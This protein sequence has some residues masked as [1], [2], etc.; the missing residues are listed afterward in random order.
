MHISVQSHTFRTNSRLSVASVVSWFVSGL[1]L[2]LPQPP[3]NEEA[4]VTISLF[5]LFFHSLL[6]SRIVPL[7]FWKRILAIEALLSFLSQG[8][9][10]A[11]QKGRL[12]F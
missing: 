3:A 11:L 7:V 8:A 6:L 12:G 9:N 1:G 4:E 5:F 10:E 2:K